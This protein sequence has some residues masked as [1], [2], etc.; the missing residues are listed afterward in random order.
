M[1]L[2]SRGEPGHLD[3][4]LHADLEKQGIHVVSTK[5]IFSSLDAMN[6]EGD[7]HFLPRRDHQIAEAVIAKTLRPNTP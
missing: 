6:F 5:D 7:S 1:L 3:D 2:H 4:W